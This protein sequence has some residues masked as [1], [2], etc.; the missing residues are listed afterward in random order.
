MKT[1]NG[2]PILSFE[3]AIDGE[4]ITLRTE[5]NDADRA[6]GTQ[7]LLT[8]LASQKNNSPA[9][10]FAN[11]PPVQLKMHESM[12]IETAI[13][14][15]K[16]VLSGRVEAGEIVDKSKLAALAAL[17]KLKE[18]LG[19]QR[20]MWELNNDVIED[21]FL[22]PAKEAI[23]KRGG[24]PNTLKKE[25][26]FIRGFFN[27]SNERK[28]RYL[29]EK[30]DL[31]VKRVPDKSYIK[32]DSNDLQNIFENLNKLADNNWEFWI[33]MIGLYSGARISEIASMEVG[34][35]TYQSGIETM[36]L[37]GSKSDAA[38]RDVPI[39]ADLISI[40]LLNLVRKRRKQGKKMLF[41][42]PSGGTN[43]PGGHASNYFTDFKRAI[44]INHEKKV[45]HSF[46]HTINDLMKQ[47]LI[48]ESAK[49][50]YIGHSLGSSVN[51]KTY[52]KTQLAVSILK[53]EV[54]DKIDWQKYCGWQPNLENLKK[55]ADQLLKT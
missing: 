17:K 55:K 22:E 32:F 27:W 28:Q 40:G 26:S 18:A 31:S 36:F 35:F 45:F 37:N 30:F 9:V 7:A 53:Q 15:Y 48:N 3:L 54:T 44:G 5:D 1:Y 24:S 2:K 13:L 19:S 38:P 23:K 39:H 43:G 34:Y 51:A 11:A 16:S 10:P 8:A 49:L 50:T 42:L 41:D 29:S 25:M 46:R 47:S 4:K 33:P 6:A 14:R 21:E 20:D 12:T 52:G